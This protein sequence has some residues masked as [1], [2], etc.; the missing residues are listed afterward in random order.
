MDCVQCLP[1]IDNADD[2]N[3]QL[4]NMKRFLSEKNC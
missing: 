3:K 2:D 4:Q 1:N